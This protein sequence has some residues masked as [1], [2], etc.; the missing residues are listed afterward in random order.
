MNKILRFMT[1]ILLL[2]NLLEIQGI[3]FQRTQ[4]STIIQGN[5]PLDTHTP[6]PHLCR[7]RYL[8]EC[9]CPTHPLPSQDPGYTTAYFVVFILR[10]NLLIYQLTSCSIKTNEVVSSTMELSLRNTTSS[11][12]YRRGQ[13]CGPF[14]L[15]FI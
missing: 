3:L 2:E 9:F 5:I 1:F 15:L 8:C 11:V 10:L 7:L 13:S 4:N 12:E 6:P 14:Y